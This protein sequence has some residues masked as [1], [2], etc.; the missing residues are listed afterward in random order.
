MV[1]TTGRLAYAVTQ[2]A[3][4][5]WFTGQYLLAFRFAT[6]RRRAAEAAAAAAPAP[7]GTRAGGTDRATARSRRRQL[8]G[9]LHRLMARDLDNI[10]A[11]YYA[12]PY[13]M[14]VRPDRPIADTVRFLRDMPVVERRRR[15]GAGDE[16]RR[17]APAGSEALPDYYRQNFHFQTDGYLSPESAR[18]Y[19]HQVEVLFT[20]GADAMRRQA[21]VPLY[22]FL[23][24]RRQGACRLVD[25]AA[26][27]GRFLTFVKDNYPLLPVTAL[28]LS[29]PY[30]DEARRRL[31]P[32]A[33][34]VSVV[35]GAA[36]H[37]PFA[38][39][40]QD[41]ITCIYLFHELP[42]PVRRAVAREFA[43]VLA[44][45]GRVIFVDSLQTGDRPPF[46]PLL[47]RF[48]HMFHEPYYR[49]Y[50]ADD[51]VGLFAEAGL[52]LSETST[53][54]LSKVMVLT[55]DA[56]AAGAVSD[57]AAAA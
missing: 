6:A 51:L 52:V 25:V 28:D 11:G 38:D 31:A 1:G 7:A 26:G 46:D 33:R 17:H 29:R 48:P 40:S 32:W 34:T 4:L 56:A 14:W 30:L 10:K 54:F 39:A 21:L 15:A 49:D 43:R 55:R 20:G 9:D 44:P 24:S 22:H 37:L 42:G 45:D 12:L 50:I 5:M 47:E 18:L 23:Q 41:V 57:R 19:D 35:R 16:V 53:A 13:D 2:T 27:T 8:I 36:E 3:R